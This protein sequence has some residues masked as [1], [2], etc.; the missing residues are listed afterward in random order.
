VALSFSTAIK[1]FS[2]RTKRRLDEVPR[3][4]MRLLY[5]EVVNNAPQ[6]SGYLRASVKLSKGAPVSVEKNPPPP[7]GSYTV[8]VAAN[9]AAIADARAGDTLYLSVTASYGWFVEFGTSTQPP[10][11][12]LRLPVMRWPAIVA[13]ATANVR[14]GR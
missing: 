11:A 14:S 3:E 10:K 1:D 6:L 12:F 7:G 5:L 13:Q 8:N 4:A 9:I 2:Q